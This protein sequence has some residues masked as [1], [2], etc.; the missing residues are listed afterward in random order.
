MSYHQVKNLDILMNELI[1]IFNLDSKVILSLLEKVSSIKPSKIH[2]KIY[3]KSLDKEFITSEIIKLI[4]EDFDLTKKEFDLNEFKIQYFFTIYHPITKISCF[5]CELKNIEGG[6]IIY[7]IV[8]IGKCED[9]F[10]LFI[11]D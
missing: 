10:Y 11:P 1:D 7:D 6:S 2:D 3:Q 5:S 8:R 4:N 9:E